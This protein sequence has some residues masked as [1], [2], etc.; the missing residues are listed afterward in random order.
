[1]NRIH[2]TTSMQDYVDHFSEL[3][4]QLKAY[5]S[6]TNTLSNI[7]RFLDGLFPEIRAVLHVQRPNSLDTVYTLALLQEEATESTRRRDYKQWNQKGALTFSLTLNVYGTGE[8]NDHI[9]T[10][11]LWIR[12][13]RTSRLFGA[14]VASA[15]IAVRNGRE[16]T[17]VPLR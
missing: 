6:A 7:T 5:D 9:R 11:S 15:T 14:L 4:D 8:L 16:I 12:S 2:Q 1:M 3:I 10:K 13:W 17:N